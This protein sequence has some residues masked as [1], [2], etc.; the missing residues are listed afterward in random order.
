MQGVNRYPRKG[1]GQWESGGGQVNRPGWFM[2][3]RCMCTLGERVMWCGCVLY[4]LGMCVYVCVRM[5][6]GGVMYVCVCLF[7]E[8]QGVKK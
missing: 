3:L 4:V 8:V 5:W 6:D 2:A 1:G 7:V